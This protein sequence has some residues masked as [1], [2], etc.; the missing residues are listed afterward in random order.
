MITTAFVK[1]WNET[2]GAVAWNTET[3]VASFEYEAKFLAKNWDLAP[4]KMP[5]NN[6]RGRI[7]T[8]T[9]LKEIK[10]FKGLPG[11]LAD[12]LP[13]D[14]GNQL[15]NSWLAQNGRPENSMNPVEMLCF[16]GT[17]GMGALEFEPSQF[18]VNKR[19]FD[20]EVDSLVAISQKMLYKRE[21][22][23][24]NLNQNEQEAM[25]NILK[26]GTS[27]G[28]ARPK[29]IIAY[30]EKTGQ[31]KSGQTNAPKGFEHWL[32]KLDTV[33]DVQFGAS[34]GYGR[35]EM[36]YYLMAR[37]AGIEMMECRLYEENGRAHFMTKRFDRENGD[38]KHHIQTLCAMQHYDFNQ[39]TSFSY[40]QLFQT[41]R[42]L[43]LPYP[44]AE[45]LYRRMVFNVIARNCD[46]HT[47]NF[48][49]RLKKEGDWELSPAYDIC[50]AYRPDS[51]WVSQHNLSING[52]RTYITREDLL[53]VAK[54]MNIK[55][56][57]TIIQ[58]IDQAVKRWYE[59]A[60]AANVENKMKESIARSH[61]IL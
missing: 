51:D 61:L 58:Q 18:N 10:T 11:L 41:M 49:F 14:Y 37:A 6:A 23:T 24:A 28:G 2:V 32:I 35:I 60:E 19:A 52:K 46:D 29:A 13:D 40:E 22:F 36:A 44:Q 1:I 17:R 39:I 56:A 54:S 45:Q 55:K 9:E 5:A 20:I 48:A 7:F 34:T 42:L 31:V 47:K 30:N 50:F 59:F 4:L 43:K 15:I 21:G 53:T 25:M 16:I 57:N 33:S 26:I 3:G 12:V 27:A 38:Q 8:F